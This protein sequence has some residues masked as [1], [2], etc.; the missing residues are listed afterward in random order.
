LSEHLDQMLAGTAEDFASAED[1]Q[2]VRTQL[3]AGL[4]NLGRHTITGALTTAGRQHLDWSADYRV[5]QRLPVERLFHH[6]QQQTLRRTAG[7]WIVAL[8]DSATRKTGRRIPGC[9]WRRDPL[10]P[11]FHVNFCWGQ[12]VLQCSAAL[13]A[14]D[15][16]ARLV[17]IDWMEAPLPKKPAKNASEAELATYA[18]ARRQANLNVLASGRLAHLRTVTD[19]AIHFVVDGRFT[20]RTVL[21]QLPENTVV[22][23]RIRKDTKLYAPAARQAGTGRP[24]RYGAELPT[25]EQLRQDE[26]TPWQEVSGWAVDGKH[27][28][29]MKTCGPVM[30]RIRG[31]TAPVRIGVIAPLGYRLR[32]GSRILY[33]QP[34][35]LLCT[36]PALPLERILQEYLWRWD[37][38][39]NFRDE[40]CLLGVSEA[41]LRHPEAVRR[42]PA[43]AVA[44]YG[45]LLLA[46]HDAY[47]HDGRPP[48]VPPPTWRRRVPP[49]RPTTA[50]LVSQLRVE[51]WSQCLRR[52]T[53]SHFR[54]R[55]RDDQK[56]DNLGAHLASAVFYAHN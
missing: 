43:A 35:Y 51:L 23:G 25:P 21:R 56:S 9:G 2:R 22:I 15:G 33:R 42:Q 10:S 7:P 8:D 17:P 27:R 37:I 20:N 6:L 28:F 5:L 41:Q 3:L 49:R 4:L 32:K 36:D 14:P 19:R 38:E 16:S 48:S 52:E 18:E 24:R 11:P 40:K 53:L 47:G 30:A 29:R 54:S 12:R 1:Y 13:P 34:A 50:H 55:P 45:L 44:A 39:V 31:V 26:Q 46:A